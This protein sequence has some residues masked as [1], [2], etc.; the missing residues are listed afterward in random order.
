MAIETIIYKGDHYP[1]L[2]GSGNAARFAKPFFDEFCKGNNG[3]DVGCNRL[4]WSFNPDANL[5]DPA[6]THVFNAN[7]LP[8]RGYDWIASSH[9]LEHYTGRWQDVLDYWLDC[10]SEKGVIFLYLP[11]MDYQK[12]WAFG[13]EKHV[14]YLNPEILRGY[15][16]DRG[17]YGF[18]TDGYDLNGSFYVVIEK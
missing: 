8:G 12:Y 14:H 13:N 4:Q 18:V 11:N 2:Q 5:I 3:C 17:L 7:N 15:M 16:R 6:I 10:L 9:M 1:A